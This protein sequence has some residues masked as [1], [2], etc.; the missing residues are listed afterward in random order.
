MPGSGTSERFYLEE[1]L[2]SFVYISA[3]KVPPLYDQMQ[4]TLGQRLSYKLHLAAPAVPGP[5][6]D[7]ALDKQSPSALV[8]KLRAVLERLAVKGQIG[9]VEAP[10]MYFAGILTMRWGAYEK[11]VFVKGGTED[12][13]VA[14]SG[15]N[16]NLIG[17]S[18]ITLPEYSDPGS[19]LAD[20][21]NRMKH[22]FTEE[23]D[24]EL[25]EDATALV[26]A[27]AARRKGPTQ[28]L[29]FVAEKLAYDDDPFN[30]LNPGVEL[31]PELAQ[32]QDV[33]F[34]VLLGTPLYLASL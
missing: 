5:S 13:L 15:S 19:A 6:L 24:Q 17:H 1:R 18:D 3:T 10:R 33:P 7:V 9:T 11:F 30:G 26:R 23:L 27:L 16:R 20:S 21:V 34:K 29:E 32:L 22:V 28:R 25:A 4:P 31:P 2:R 14:L 8:G 12:T